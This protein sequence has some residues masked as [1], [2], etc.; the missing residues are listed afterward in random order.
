MV[1]ELEP[2][3]GGRWRFALERCTGRRYIVEE[4]AKA[5]VPASAVSRG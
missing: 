5:A 2:T 1:T 4:M 3:A